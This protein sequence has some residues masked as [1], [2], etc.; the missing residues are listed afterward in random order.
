GDY[1]SALAHFA[2]TLVI[3][4]AIGNRN[5]IASSLNNLGNV[6]TVQGDYASAQAYLEETLVMRREFGERNGIARSLINLAMVAS[7][8]D[9][10]VSARTYLEESLTLLREIGDRTSIVAALAGFADIALKERGANRAA[11]LWAAAE[12]LRQQLGAPMPPNEREGYDRN[13]AQVHQALD[14][15]AFSAAWAIGTAMTLEQAMDY[16]LQD[17]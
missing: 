6:A 16:A 11:V 2:E 1:A 12:T 4:R 17:P 13:I 8:Q 15:E 9:D 10:Y 5:G 14:E 7:H 3:R